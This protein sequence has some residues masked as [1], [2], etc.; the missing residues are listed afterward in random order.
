MGITLE[1]QELPVPE[2]C[3]IPCQSLGGCCVICL[4]SVTD[5]FPEKGFEEVSVLCEVFAGELQGLKFSGR[6]VEYV[7]KSFVIC[8][9]DNGI[10]LCEQWRSVRPARW[11]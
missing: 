2:R 11:Q 6:I 10:K 3:S 8:S 7:V 5:N 4:K 1:E 9:W